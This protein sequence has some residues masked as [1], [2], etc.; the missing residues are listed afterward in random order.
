MRCM[1]VAD[2]GASIEI[3]QPFCGEVWF[4]IADINLLICAFDSIITVLLS[5]IRSYLFPSPSVEGGATI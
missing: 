1:F 4:R 2:V 5:F 3:S